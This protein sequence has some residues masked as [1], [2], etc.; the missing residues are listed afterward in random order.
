MNY[1]EGPTS[2]VNINYNEH[3]VRGSINLDVM[4]HS[5]MNVAITQV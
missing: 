5:R 2:K 4:A 1:F 3:I